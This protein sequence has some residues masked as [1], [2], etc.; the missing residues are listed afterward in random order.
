MYLFV[1]KSI[2]TNYPFS[3][4]SRGEGS[5]EARF[6]CGYCDKS[7]ATPS[8]VKRHILTHTGEKPFVCQFCQRGFSQKVHMMEHISKHHADESLK[9][10]QEA[11]AAAA[12][13]AA[14]AQ[15]AAPAP[16]IKTLPSNK[17]LYA[18]QTIATT[19]LISNTPNQPQIRLQPAAPQTIVAT[20]PSNTVVSYARAPLPPSAIVSA[21]PVTAIT[22]AVSSLPAQIVAA[23]PS[24]TFTTARQ[25]QQTQSQTLTAALADT[26][27]AVQIPL[28]GN[29]YIVAEFSM[30]D[31]NMSTSPPAHHQSHHQVVDTT[32]SHIISGSKSPDIMAI[33]MT[34]HQLTAEFGGG[35][36]PSS[37]LTKPGEGPFLSQA[38][39]G[40]YQ[41]V[42]SSD[43]PFPCT[44]C[45]AD[46][47]R[48]SNLSVHMMKVHGE[49]VE[50][51]THQCAYCDKRFRYPNK[52]R[53]HEMTHTGEKPNICQ[54]CSLGFF[55]KS[56]LKCHLTKVH[57]IPE[58]DLNSPNSQ[59]LQNPSSTTNP[60]HTVMKSVTLNN[61]TIN[62]VG[63]N[64]GTQT[65]SAG[66]D[67]FCQYCQK[68]FSNRADLLLHE[69]QEAM[70]FEQLH[71]MFEDGELTGFEVG[72]SQTDII[73]NALLTAGIENGLGSPSVTDSDSVVT[74]SEADIDSFSIGFIPD[75][76]WTSEV[77]TNL[78]TS[79]TPGDP[80]SPA[81]LQPLD[82][83]I[84]T[85]DG[86][87]V[88]CSSTAT[89]AND[90][91]ISG[92]IYTTSD[93]KTGKYFYSQ[94][95]SKSSYL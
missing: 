28:A 64:N 73:Q 3:R 24:Q 41:V 78:P 11:A 19:P 4:T 14:A 44:H 85:S 60:T 6:Q 92:A 8:K 23:Q 82:L 32:N 70:E 61:S 54:F 10:Q 40:S 80:F 26:T 52:K 72:N 69:R 18:T 25:H 17:T 48:Q 5:K 55:K 45:S 57:G 50:I 49:A 35:G 87:T 42:Q 93:Y 68:P 21:V 2:N 67:H 31:S 71:D 59:Y 83:N 75:G 15:A 1:Y 88:V 16:L 29:S 38:A 94:I 36:S 90:L 34:Q 76:N 37:S 95:F 58:D 62:L 66:G 9:A 81:G 47:I 46:F 13:Q 89:S 20:Q 51:R 74:I 27:G 30:P 79:N 91:A 43:K 56:R 33:P 39:A 63:S 84:N 65:I 86:H 12:A 77:S 53:L 22:T 7:F